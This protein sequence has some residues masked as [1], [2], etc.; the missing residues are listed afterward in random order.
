MSSVTRGGLLI[1]FLVGIGA[2]IAGETGA[3]EPDEPPVADAKPS[4][5]ATP[6]E[7]APPE[8]PAEDKPADDEPAKEKPPNDVAEKD[9]DG[10]EWITP[11]VATSEERAEEDEI[12]RASCRERVCHNV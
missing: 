4:L 2:S 3:Q 12:G 8:E 7:Q 6:K 11:D 9:V 1:A 10:K 5:E